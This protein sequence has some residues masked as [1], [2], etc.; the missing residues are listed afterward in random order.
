MNETITR[1]PDDV[2]EV[3]SNVLTTYG[4]HYSN[5]SIVDGILHLDVNPG[6]N[7]KRYSLEKISHLLMAMFSITTLVLNGVLYTAAMA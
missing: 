5:G 1:L 7:E 6:F 2:T 4:L 3:V